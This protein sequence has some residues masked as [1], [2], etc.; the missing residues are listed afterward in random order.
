V[1][2]ANK[3]QQVPRGGAEANGKKNDPV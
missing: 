2:G 1:S 3:K